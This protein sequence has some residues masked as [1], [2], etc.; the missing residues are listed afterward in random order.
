MTIRIKNDNSIAI[1]PIPSNFDT[2]GTQLAASLEEESIVKG[3]PVQY[4]FKPSK[5]F[6]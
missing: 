5:K 6:H 2:F 4:N 1:I 3:I